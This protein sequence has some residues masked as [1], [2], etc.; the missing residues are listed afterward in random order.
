MLRIEQVF[1][2]CCCGDELFLQTIV[3]NFKYKEKLYHK[4]FDNDC[5]SIMRL[6]DWI[7]GNPYIFTKTDYDVC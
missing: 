2:Y 6:I 3:A 1:K 4:S 7:R 5:K